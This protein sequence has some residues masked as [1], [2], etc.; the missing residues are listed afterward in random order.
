M[1]FDFSNLS[2]EQSEFIAKL[3]TMG[4]QNVSATVHADTWGDKRTL[5]ISWLETKRKAREL[6]AADDADE[7]RRFTA[8]AL[9]VTRD[10]A[11]AA[12]RSASWTMVA[13][14]AAAARVVVQLAITAFPHK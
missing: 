10:A 8:E 5:A 3:E 11:E 4:E 9:R 7:S 13:A 12:K 2:P 14:M 6:K 1:I